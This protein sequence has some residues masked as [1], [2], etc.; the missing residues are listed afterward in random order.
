MVAKKVSAKKSAA[1]TAAS[2][3]STAKKTA[4]KKATSKKA[5]PAKATSRKPAK[6]TPVNTP[7]APTPPTIDPNPSGNTPA[8]G[9]VFANPKETADDYGNFSKADVF[10][11]SSAKPSTQL[12]PVPAPW[13]TPSVLS[14]D[15]V[16]GAAA[17][18]QITATKSITF[19]SVGDTG[20]IHDPAKQ[21]A[22]ADAM[23]KDLG[24]KTYSSGLPAFFFHLGDVV[25][26]LGQE[27]YYYEQ[28]YDPY[29]DYDAPIFAIPGNHDGMISPSVKQTTLQGFVENFCTEAPSKNPEAQGLSRTTMTQPGVYFTLQAPFVDIIGLY[30]NISEGATEGVISGS[31]AGPAQLAFLQQQLTATA[32]ARKSGTRKALILAVHH[33]PFTGSQDHAPS[34]TM[35]KQIDAACTAAGIFPDMVLSGH[36]HLYERYTRTIN[37]SQIPFIVAGIGGYWNLSGMKKGTNNQ[38]PTTPFTGTDASGNKLVLEK[39]NSTTFG[40]LSLTIS[41]DTIALTFYGVTPGVGGQAASVAIVDQCTVDLNKHTVT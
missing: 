30:S 27:L 40:F 1:K 31:V 2:K 6:T 26:Y 9:F 35:L 12:Q 24:D 11:D 21:F 23:A 39:F 25:Y 20:G 7:A 16:L 29:R 36:A 32:A 14:L 3:P 19:H 4:A 13:K 15:Q 33:P 28:F 34:P 38:T 22:V 18:A 37:N 8:T 5:S 41:A 10:A 17:V